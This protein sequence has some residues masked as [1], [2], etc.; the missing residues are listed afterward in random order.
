[1]E[2]AR[3]QKVISDSGFC[4]RRKAE[5][6]IE[7]GRVRVN[8]RPA[9]IGQKVIAKDV[10]TIDGE[11]LPRREKGQCQYL[12]LYKPRGY[13]TAVSDDRGRKCVTELL[14]GVSSRVYPVGRLDL[15]SEGLL[16]LTDDGEFANVLTHPSHKI[17]KGYRV[18]TH[19]PVGDAEILALSEGVEI[20][21]RKTLPAEVRVVAEEEHRTVLLITIVEGRNRQIRKMCEAVGLSVAR[22]KRVSVGPLRLGMLKPGE[23]R[24]LTKDE[25]DMLLDLGR[26]GKK[27]SNRRQGGKW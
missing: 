24:R 14:N 13:L 25:V 9:H 7:D 18:T 4:S 1:M 2:E 5:A 21:G 22:L 16:L 10:I 3:L 17:P 19:D 11:K 15:N 12:L 20:D 26:R 27:A 23:Y 8:G 6:L